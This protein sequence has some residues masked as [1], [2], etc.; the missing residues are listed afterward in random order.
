MPTLPAAPPI[1]PA[2]GSET[3]RTAGAE[4]LDLPTPRKENSTWKLVVGLAILAALSAA[5]LTA[6]SVKGLW[7]LLRAAFQES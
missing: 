3:I 6:P 5:I 2:P 4:T 1:L 7:Q